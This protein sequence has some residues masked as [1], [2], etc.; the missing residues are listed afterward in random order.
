LTGTY[1]NATSL[2]EVYGELAAE[3]KMDDLT[4]AWLS[5][6]PGRTDLPILQ[7]STELF[8]ELGK[9]QEA[10]QIALLA[11]LSDSEQYASRVSIESH[12]K[13]LGLG[14]FYA[15][16][17]FHSIAIKQVMDAQDPQRT[18]YQ[19]LV[20]R[21]R[22]FTIA[23]ARGPATG[24]LDPVTV[25]LREYPTLPIVETLGLVGRLARKH[26]THSIFSIKPTIPFWISGSMASDAGVEMCRRVDSNWVRNRRFVA[27]A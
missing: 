8:P 5:D 7:V 16:N 2:S 11:L 24:I 27:R 25:E 6:L 26:K 10:Q 20:A 1:W 17:H 18:N 22:K 3:C 21:R 15:G 14:H 12:L 4:I 23:K 19:A 13:G 9:C